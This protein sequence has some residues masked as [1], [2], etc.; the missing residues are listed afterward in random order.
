M[1]TSSLSYH[2]SPDHLLDCGKGSRCNE[3]LGNL[4]SLYSTQRSY[5][6]QEEEEHEQLIFPSDHF[7]TQLP[8]R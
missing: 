7:L 2:W 1:T 8:T 5:P 4:G 3:K 6:G